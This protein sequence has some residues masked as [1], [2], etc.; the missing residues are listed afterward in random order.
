MRLFAE[1]ERVRVEDVFGSWAEAQATHF[2]DGGV[3][4]RLYRPGN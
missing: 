4:D 1:V 3:F 2:A